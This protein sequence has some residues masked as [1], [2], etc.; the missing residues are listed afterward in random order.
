MIV[1]VHEEA[2]NFIY[3]Y[4]GSLRREIRYLGAL[5]PVFAP[6]ED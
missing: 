2:N 5:H 4:K 1:A 3:C 6:G